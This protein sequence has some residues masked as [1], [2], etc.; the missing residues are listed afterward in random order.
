M[1]LRL[2]Y[3]ILSALLSFGCATSGQ[4]LVVGAVDVPQISTR[5]S[6]KLLTVPEALAQVESLRAKKTMVGY[7]QALDLLNQIVR[8]DESRQPLANAVQGEFDDYLW[9]VHTRFERKGE[10]QQRDFDAHRAAPIGIPS[11]QPPTDF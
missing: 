6:D 9:A 8:I 11:S 7:Q 1:S 2:A 10:D 3:C 4:T 5:D